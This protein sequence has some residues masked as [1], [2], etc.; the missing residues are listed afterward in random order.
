VLR[1][2]RHDASARC[3]SSAVPFSPTRVSMRL[4]LK[5]AIWLRLESTI[6]VTLR[7]R[8]SKRCRRASVAVASARALARAR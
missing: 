1:S 7:W 4:C 8:F 5:F 3:L 2:V 6:A